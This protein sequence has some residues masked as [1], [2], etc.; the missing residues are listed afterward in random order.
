MRFFNSLVYDTEEINVL[1]KDFGENPARNYIC[2][3]DSTCKKQI[4]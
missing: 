1:Q 3:L 2:T 4:V